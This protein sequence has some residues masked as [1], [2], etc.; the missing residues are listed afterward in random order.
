MK[1]ILV[2]KILFLEESLPRLPC[3]VCDYGYMVSFWLL[4][5]VPKESS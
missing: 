4:L 2:L 3:L 5:G 1:G